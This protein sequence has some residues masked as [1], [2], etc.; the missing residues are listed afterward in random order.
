M[1]RPTGVPNLAKVTADAPPRPTP[2]TASIGHIQ[3]RLDA[4]PLPKP[5]H[6]ATRPAPITQAYPV[7]VRSRLAKR[8]RTPLAQTR[9]LEGRSM[10][11]SKANRLP[12]VSGMLQA[13]SS[14]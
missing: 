13:K 11:P 4:P 7:G 5:N 9:P 2:A 14:L 8:I 6:R 1:G 3:R 10:T 12:T